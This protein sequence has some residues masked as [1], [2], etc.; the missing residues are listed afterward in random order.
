MRPAFALVNFNGGADLLD[1]IRS[2]YAQTVAP[3]GV[4]I[5]DNG[6]SDGSLEAAE[7]AF[8]DVVA[9]RLPENLGFGAAANVAFARI[10]GDPLIVL[11]PDVVLRPA[12]VEAVIDAF[13]ADPGIGIVGGKLLYPDER[14]IQHAGGIIIRPLML[15]DHRQYG[16][17]DGPTDEA[18]D[19]DYVTGAALAIRQ[20]AFESLDG[21]DPHYF[22]Y[23]EE[24]DLCFRARA[25]GWRVHYRPDA[26]GIHRESMSVG[27]ESSRYY[28]WYHTSRVRFALTH[29]SAATVLTEFVPAERDRLAAVVSRDELAGLHGA[30]VVNVRALSDAADAALGGDQPNLRPALAD[31][32][33]GLAALAL[34]AVPVESRVA[35]VEA[36][37]FARLAGLIFRSD[38]PIVGGLIVAFRTLWNDISARWYLQPVIDRQNEINQEIARSLLRIERRLAEIDARVELQAGWLGDLDRDLIEHARRRIRS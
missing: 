14:T 8:P 37:S 32:L 15:A 12:W 6:S 23:Y 7:A 17:S 4:A 18:C 3:V 28:L 13:A 38:M 27:R 25:A 33:A 16:E 20:A 35:P 10:G 34:T 31:S 24:A 19:V 36:P 30:F 9:I 1:A 26:V 5:V 21:F 11:N 22:L 29:L 2:V